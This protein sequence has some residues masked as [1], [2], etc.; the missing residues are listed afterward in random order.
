MGFLD[1]SGVT[2]L[3]TRLKNKFTEMFQPTLVSGQNIKTVN[4]TSLLGSGD[5]SISGGSKVWVGS[6]TTR[7]TKADKVV[8][9]TGFT[10]TNNDLLLVSFAYP[11]GVPQALT[12]NVNGTGAM[13][14]YGCDGII[15]A[16]NPLTWGAKNA[17]GS[18]G[19]YLLFQV[20]STYYLYL[21]AALG[22]DIESPNGGSTWY[23]D[24][25][26]AAATAEKAVIC[27]SQL[28]GGYYQGNQ[29]SIVAVRF[30]NSNTYTSGALSL[31]IDGTG[32]KTIYV[33]GVATSSSNTLLWDGGE[34]LLFMVYSKDICL[35]LCRDKQSGGGASV[36]T[37][38]VTIAT[39]DW[40]NGS[41][42]KNVTG[43]TT[44]NS[45][46]VTYDP[47]S[48]TDYVN[49]D[50]YCSAQGT[51]TLTFNCATAPSSSVTVNV[52]IIS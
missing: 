23:G 24:S 10:R 51:G 4:S 44:T 3:T 34:T 39:G 31:N 42:T 8:T 36:S 16:S 11:S 52:M 15:S 12:L 19:G 6:C 33:N 14:V 26:T 50:I 7:Y 49:S 40:S 2:E 1:G 35:Y 46:I 30:S 9:C 28:R 22:I 45:V 13:P 18:S 27:G 48:R 5:I 43:I 21:D 29:G 38:T 25:G 32:A 47:S 17:Q 20:R 37:T 41:C